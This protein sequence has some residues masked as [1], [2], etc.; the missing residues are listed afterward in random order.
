M[1]EKPFAHLMGTRIAIENFVVETK[2]EEK[3]DIILLPDDQSR[4]DA[5]KMDEDI[6]S[7]KRF[8]IIQVGEECNEKFK[9]GQEVYIEN[10]ERVLS[11]E[12]A[13]SVIENDCIIAFI[14]PERSIAGIF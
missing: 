7:T 1:S 5:E 2:E 12:N 14:V 9:P 6:T 11:P 13:T 3:S 10:P 4:V 8:K